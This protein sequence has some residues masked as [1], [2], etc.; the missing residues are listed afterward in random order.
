LLGTAESCCCCCSTVTKTKKGTAT[1]RN[2]HT[3]KTG[4]SHVTWRRHTSGRVRY[5]TDILRRPAFSSTYVH[6]RAAS[7]IAFCFYQGRAET[8]SRLRTVVYGQERANAPN[9]GS[10]FWARMTSRVARRHL[11]YSRLQ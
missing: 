1:K 7:R 5:G 10:T 9:L 6:T 4:A 2:D 3:T 8:I 11:Q